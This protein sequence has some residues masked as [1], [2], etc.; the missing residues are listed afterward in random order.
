MSVSPEASELADHS[1]SLQHGMIKS[2]YIGD[3]RFEKKS[4]Y[5]VIY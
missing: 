2:V 4:A 5:D 1:P 3:F